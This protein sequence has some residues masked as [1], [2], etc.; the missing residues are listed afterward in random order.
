MRNPLAGLTV[1]AL[2][3]SAC[4]DPPWVGTYTVS[5]DWDL[6]GP[7]TPGR[8]IGDAV[9]DI[10]VGKIALTT[11]CPGFLEDD[12]FLELVDLAGSHIK[13]M[14]DTNAPAELGPNGPVT[15]FLSSTLASVRTT[16]KLVLDEAIIDDLEG[17]ETIK[18]M[19]YDLATGAQQLPP[20]NL[21]EEEG[22]EMVAEW[23][24][25]ESGESGFEIDQH[26][27]PIQY[28]AMLAEVLLHLLD[29]AGLDNL[30]TGVL[31]ALD[32]GTLVDLIL[33]GEPG[34]DISIG[35][36]TYTIPASDFRDACDS[37]H[38]AMGS[39]VLGVFSSDTAVLVGGKISWSDG[40]PVELSTPDGFS[41]I[42]D[43]APEEVA[44][45]IS[46]TFTA[47]RKGD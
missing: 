16:S 27:V 31:A 8:T 24:G 42:L 39:K 11:P 15:Q 40:D 1:L 25:D 5:A 2:M 28:G 26:N 45:K 14:V 32:C 47:K 13:T 19:E 43:V 22:E 44:P 34:W 21:F 17:E 6:R 10:V 46:V 33:E 23:E 37:A 7:F 18:S 12:L 29:A 38:E 3:L 30:R 9:S 36:W 35:D 20:G 41:G 4:G